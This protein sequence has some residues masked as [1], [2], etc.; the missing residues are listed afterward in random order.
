[1]RLCNSRRRAGGCG[2]EG[3]SVRDSACRGECFFGKVPCLPRVFCD[4]VEMSGGLLPGE[5]RS[6]ISSSSP[7][8]PSLF[9]SKVA[10]F[11][12][13]EGLA[14]LEAVRSSIVYMFCLRPRG[15]D[16]PSRYFPWECHLRER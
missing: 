8:P 7:E 6:L 2:S 14:F 5:S 9:F 3:G 16:V 10:A 12:P 11:P 4:G 1:M 13:W 15:M